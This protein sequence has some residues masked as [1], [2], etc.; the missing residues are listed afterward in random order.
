MA[1]GPEE[2]GDARAA[3]EWLRERGYGLIFTEGDGF[4]WANLV[5]L[6][7]ESVIAARYGRGTD[8]ETATLRAKQRY[9]QEQ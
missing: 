6:E 2:G 1:T 3:A 7:T 8:K 5:S 4:V 9:R